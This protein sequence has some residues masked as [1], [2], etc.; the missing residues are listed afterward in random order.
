MPLRLPVRPLAV[1][2]TCAATLSAQSET[3]T[4][5]GT[6]A[7]IYNLVG[8]ITVEPSTGNEIQVEITRRG[9][10]ARRLNIDVV[11][12]GG[13]QSLR[14]IFPD[15]DIVYPELGRWNRSEFNLDRDGRWNRGGDRGWFSRRRIRV[16]GNGRGTEAWADLRVLVPAGKRVDVNAGVGSVISRGVSS[17]LS[18][19]V[20]TAHVRVEGHTGRLRLDTGSGGAEARDIKGD[21]LNVDV[22]SGRVTVMGADVQRLNLSSG[23]GGVEIDRVTAAEMYVDVGSGGMRVSRATAD[24]M[25]LDTGSGSVNVELTNSPRSL[26]VDSGSGG[27]TLYLPSSLDAEIDISTGSGSI[28]SD[29]P[30]SVT[31]MERRRLRGT[32][33]KGTGRIHVETGSGSVRLRRM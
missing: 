32:V 28:D 1:L 8:S 27:V 19:D 23:S 9:I 24:R 33:G 13:G 10:D 26:D 22:G 14:I 3:R 6:S 21:E 31:R 16:S 25:R 30:V 20:A 5:S 17:E 2:A 15:D 4:L 7:S 29:F 11:G 18:I 12:E